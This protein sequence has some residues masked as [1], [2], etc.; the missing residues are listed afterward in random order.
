MINLKPNRSTFEITPQ[1]RSRAPVVHQFWRISIVFGL[2]IGFPSGLYL[3]LQLGGQIQ[4]AENYLYIVN[5]H[6]TSQILIFFGLFILGF[7][8]TAGYHLNGGQARPVKQIFWVLP[9]IAVGFILHLFQP[10]EQVGKLIISA[11]FA[12]TGLMMLGAAK[13]GRFSKPVITALCLPALITFTAAPW[14]QLTDI[15]VAFFVVLTGPFFFVLMAGLQLIPNVMK[16]DRLEGTPGW[17]FIVL[18]MTSYLLIAY[19]AFVSQVNPALIALS[20]MLPVIMYLTCV[21]LFKALNYCGPT[22]LA[23]AFIAGFSWFFAAMVLLAIHGDT[24]MENALHLIVLGQVTTHVIAVGARVIGF[25]SG[26]YAI[27][28]VRLTRLVLLWQLVPFTRG[29]DAVI[30]FPAGTAWITTVTTVAVLLPWSVLMLARIRK[31]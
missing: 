16:G 14:L 22:S 1:N 18:M 10:L 25:F 19:S 24:F 29:L 20:L 3:W 6:A 7:V 9:A 13:E 31:V 4:P 2:L 21:N 5:L 26:D 11:S 28:D 23:I 17:V 8:Y 12:Y 30:D 27:S 15:N